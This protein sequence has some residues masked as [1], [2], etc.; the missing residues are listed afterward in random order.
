MGCKELDSEKN[1]ET[2]KHPLSSGIPCTIHS[3]V[4]CCIETRMPLSRTDIERI[5]QQ[6]YRFKDFVVKRKRERRLKNRNGRCVF[7][8]DKGCKI[9]SFRP[10]GCRLYPLVY[11]ENDRKFVIHDLCPYAHEFKV[12]RDDIENLHAFFKELS[13]KG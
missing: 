7:L 11:N 3:C 6:G 12:S 8:G 10:E 4:K 13:K 2:K 1:N 9:Y 5:S